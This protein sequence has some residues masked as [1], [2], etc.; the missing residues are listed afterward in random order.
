MKFLVG[1]FMHETNTFSR[2][3]ASLECFAEQGIW[4]GEGIPERV[5]GSRTSLGAFIDVAARSDQICAELRQSF[6][7]VCIREMCR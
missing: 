7:V 5:A 1:E 6:C 2:V 4:T 3:P